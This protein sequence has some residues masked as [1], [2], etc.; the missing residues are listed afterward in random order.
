MKHNLIA[1]LIALAL[2][3]SIAAIAETAT[4]D[5]PAGSQLPSPEDQTQQT[6]P[7]QD[8]AALKDAMDAYRAA[9]QAGKLKALEDEL[10]GYVESGAMTREQADLILKN[11]QDRAA[12]RN[13]TCPGCGY[14]FNSGK[15]GRGMNGQ[16]KQGRMGGQGQQGK[17]GRMGGGMGKMGRGMMNGQQPQQP[18]Q[19]G[20]TQAYDGI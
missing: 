10:N 1:I 2:T 3:L 14:Q 20:Q 7:A 6:A 8:D 9:K 12:L 19:P 13:G 15:Q 11:A 4:P 17:Q 16:G 18:Q 5:V